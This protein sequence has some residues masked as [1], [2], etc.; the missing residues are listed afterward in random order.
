MGRGSQRLLRQWPSVLVAAL[1]LLLGTSHAALLAVD[2]GSEWV[3]ASLVSHGRVPVSI[4]L[5]EASKRKFAAAVGLSA[6]ERTIGD[7]ALALVTRYPE[8][9][10][11]KARDLLGRRANSTLLAAHLSA[12][13]LPYTPL[14][15]VPG[16]GTVAFRTAEQQAERQQLTAEEAAASLLQYVVRCAR[17]QLP[18]GAP[19]LRDAVITIPP[20]WSQAQRAALVDAAALAGLNLLSLVSEPLAA[21][22]QYGIDKAPPGEGGVEHVVFVDIGAG[23]STASLV[24]YSSYPSRDAKGKLV[25][26][27]EIKAVTWDDAAGAEGLDL[28]IAGK[29][30]VQGGLRVCHQCNSDPIRFPNSAE[31]FA[32]EANAKLGG[33]VD[34]RNSP[35]S[36]AKLKKQAKRTKEILSANAEAPFSVES[37]HEDTDFRSTITRETFEQLAGPSFARM[38]APLKALLTSSGVNPSSIVAV[39]LIGGGTRVPG[40]QA[41][42]VKALGGRALDKH[43]DADETLAMGAGLV[44]ANLSTTF[45][46]RKYG[47]ADTAVFGMTL[48]RDGGGSA[49]AGVHDDGELGDE[50]GSGATANGGAAGGK[51]LLPRGKRLPAKRLVSYTGISADFRLTARYDA[52]TSEQLPPSAVADGGDAGHIA[53][54]GVSGVTSAPSKT[55][56]STGKVTATFLVGRDGILVLD[57]VELGVEFLET[58][59]EL[60]PANITANAT[61]AAPPV[62][63][64]TNATSG[65]SSANGTNTTAAPPPPPPPPAMVKVKRSRLRAS[66]VPL[67]VTLLSSPIPPMSAQQRAASVTKL[68]ALLAEDEARAA[69]GKAKSGLEA[70]IL[71]MREH[72]EGEEPS[73]LHGVTSPK[74]RE[75]F[76]KALVEAEEWLYGDGAD[77]NAAT[78]TGKQAALRE[79]GDPMELRLAEQSARP[80]AVAAA[81][82]A[83]GDVRTEVAA[84][85]KSRPHINATERT[86][87]LGVADALD[88]WLTDAETKQGKAAVHDVPVLLSGEV[89]NRT[90][91]L[92][93]AFTRLKRKPVPKP[94][95]AP[96]VVVPGNAT[97]GEDGASPPEE[98]EATPGDQ[99]EAQ[100]PDGAPLGNAPDGDGEGGAREEHDELR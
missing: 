54:W 32:K 9:T 85:E 3:K 44:A 100:A 2:Y 53:T 39:E 10:Y 41:A 37:I 79:Q 45:R 23:K 34:V 4:V 13:Y 25:G 50:A 57:K 70:Y 86:E 14:L 87:L 31:H 27:F 58:Y 1:L 21:A 20:Y 40:V 7:E 22:V 95:P 59:D 52:L 72:L 42:L 29:R 8:R 94:P 26:Q 24:A 60:V 18:A 83:M 75:K 11:L 82:A 55:H 76:L 15:A 74:Q 43:L 51:V 68:G 47:A 96:K 56:N 62:V 80:K 69:T 92:Q 64:P 93:A 6:G 97:S 99:G 98:G 16:R 12:T 89:A 38:A 66:R 36:M 49:G 84:W 63:L 28:L 81:R 5:T 77:G 88:K 35:R 33:G 78:F 30:L 48:Q 91:S 90:A 46:M 61:A 19:P 17:E 67:T 65:N 73:G 71:R